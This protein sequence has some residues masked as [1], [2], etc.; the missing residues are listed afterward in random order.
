VHAGIGFISADTLA[1]NPIFA[2]APRKIPQGKLSMAV[3][4]CFE[5]TSSLQYFSNHLNF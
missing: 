4:A 5:A 2:K 3:A 1:D